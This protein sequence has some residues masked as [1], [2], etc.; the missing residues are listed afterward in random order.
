M[1]WQHHFSNSFYGS[2]SVFPQRIPRWGPGGYDG[3]V[4]AALLH[5]GQVLF[6]TADETTLLWNPNDTTP[7]TFEDPVNQPHL[8]PDAASGYSVLCSG[9]SFLSDGQLLVV[10][11]GGYGPHSKAM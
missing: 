9:H 1:S 3:V 11:G 8:T 10:G 7:A 5:T 6:I 2:W 4:H